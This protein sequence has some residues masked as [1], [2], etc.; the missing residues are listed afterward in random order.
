MKRKKELTF[1]F[2]HFEQDFALR[3]QACRT[4]FIKEETVVSNLSISRIKHRELG[5]IPPSLL[6]GL[7]KK[8]NQIVQA[9]RITELSR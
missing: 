4:A 5:S 8:G 6:Q 2:C 3:Q 9:S 1:N 7:G